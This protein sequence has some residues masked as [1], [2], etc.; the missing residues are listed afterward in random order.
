MT[1]MLASVTGPEEAHIA[2]AGGAD[3]IDL[4][5]PARGALGAVSPATIRATASML[6]GRVPLSAVTGDLPMEPDQVFAA[7]CDAADA[8]AAIVKIGIFPG[9]EPVRCIR[10]L[11]PLATR[12]ELVAVLFADRAPDLSLLPL[13]AE[14]G[15]A[16][17]M[18]DTAGKGGGGLIDHMDLPRLRRFTA[19][20][21]A[22]GLF[23]GLAGALERPDIPRLLVLHPAVL[24][25]RSALCTG[26]RSGPIAP[27]AVQAIRALIPRESQGPEIRR[28]VSGT[29]TD[30]V[31]L[32]DWVLPVRIGVYAREREAPQR[33]RFSV[34]AVVERLNA[35]T[36]ALGDVFSY[37][38]ISDGIRMLTEGEHIELAETLAERIAA[39]VLAHPRVAKVT[40]SVE[41]LEV[42]TGVVGVSIERRRDDPVPPVELLFGAPG[43]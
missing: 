5:D 36:R 12:T 2:L 35:P 18:L 42:G 32:R 26:G 3:I 7:A 11:K 9:G 41:K 21:R 30:L 27:E 34:E 4:K 15:F 20:C 16:G 33:V 39:L 43:G 37:D 23:A 10:A 19:E 38:I 1:K 8:G 28:P 25:F 29:R 17:A 6:E 40:V 31:F 24:G 14:A 22:N 13:L